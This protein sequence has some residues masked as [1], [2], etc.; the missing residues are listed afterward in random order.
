MWHGR[1]PQPY[2]LEQITPNLCL[3]YISFFDSATNTISHLVV[4]EAT[5]ACAV[6]DSVLDYNEPNAAKISFESADAIIELIENKACIWNGSVETHAHAD[7]LSAAPYIQQKLGGKL[8]LG[9]PLKPSRKSLEKSSILERI[10]S[11]CQPI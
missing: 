5:K 3:K 11:R 10:C 6:I 2:A 8:P 7:H 1:T 9:N 4:D